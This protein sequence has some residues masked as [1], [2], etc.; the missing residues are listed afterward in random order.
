MLLLAAKIIE[1]ILLSATAKSQICNYSKSIVFH[2]QFIVLLAEQ[3]LAPCF[4]IKAGC[5]RVLEPDLSPL[6]YKP[7]YFSVVDANIAVLEGVASG[8]LC[9]E[10]KNYIYEFAFYLKL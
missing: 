1:I 7:N 3:D 2:I 4:F 10:S 9:G 8:K 5:Q 6:L